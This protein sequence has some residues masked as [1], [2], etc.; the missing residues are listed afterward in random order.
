MTETSL[1][2]LDPEEKKPVSTVSFWSRSTS[3]SAANPESQPDKAG[4]LHPFNLGLRCWL[5]GGREKCEL[6]APASP[7]PC[8]KPHEANTLMS[9]SIFASSN[10]PSNARV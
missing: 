5:C 7:A 6:P 8:T 3:R 10:D 1:G 2:S 4:R 9:V